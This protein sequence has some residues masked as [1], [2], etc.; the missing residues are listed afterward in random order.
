MT[1][2]PISTKSSGNPFA[3]FGMAD[4]ETRLAKA[5]IAME[6]TAIMRDRDLT[7]ARIAEMLGIDQPQV[8]RIVRGRLK[9]FS[10]DKLIELVRRLN[11]DVDISFRENPEP[12]RPA[13]MVVHSSEHAIAATGNL[14]PTEGVQF[15]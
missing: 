1:D 14:S 10:I 3:D 6:I 5:R 13:R 7:Q 9:D 11:I 12:S 15:D 4:A 2:Q 8:S